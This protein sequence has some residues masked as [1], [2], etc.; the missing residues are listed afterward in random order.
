M[1]AAQEI[2]DLV[3]NA[4]DGEF[5]DDQ[6]IFFDAMSTRGSVR[7]TVTDAET[8]ER[9]EYVLQIVAKVA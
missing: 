5:F 4:L 6:G 3:S 1:R 8:D 7:L 9:A 2:A